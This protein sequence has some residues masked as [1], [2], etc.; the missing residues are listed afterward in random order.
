MA[1]GVDSTPSKG[2]AED[3]RAVL[4]ASIMRKYH[5]HSFEFDE[6]YGELTNF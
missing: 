3:G 6:T 5:C 4:R 1:D 2:F